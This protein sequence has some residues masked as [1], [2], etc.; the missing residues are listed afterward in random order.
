MRARKG[1][2]A[3]QRSPMST[4]RRPRCTNRSTTASNWLAATSVASPEE[5]TRRVSNTK[6]PWP[7]SWGRRTTLLITQ[8]GQTAW[9]HS[10]KLGMG[11]NVR[12]ADVSASRRYKLLVS[13]PRKTYSPV[14]GSGANWTKT[15]RSFSASILPSSKASYRLGQR[16]WNKRERDNYGKLWAAYS[17]LSASTV[18]NSASPACLKHPQT[19]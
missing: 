1:A 8:P 19:A 18:L 7:A 17:L 11:T 5:A 6:V 10:G 3:Y 12:S 2:Q 14:P 9:L 15:W 4:G 13:T 16:R